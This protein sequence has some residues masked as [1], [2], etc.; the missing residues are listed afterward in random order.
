MDPTSLWA[1]KD[2]PAKEH[3]Q[4]ALLGRHLWKRSLVRAYGSYH[5][6][7]SCSEDFPCNKRPLKFSKPDEIDECDL[8]HNDEETEAQGE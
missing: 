6:P 4:E 7:G 3:M 8:H 5:V 2:P 1:G